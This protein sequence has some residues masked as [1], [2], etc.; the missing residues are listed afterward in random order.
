VATDLGI[1]AATSPPGVQVE[2]SDSHP[3]R[4]GGD[5]QNAL[6]EHYTFS[7]G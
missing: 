7:T 4:R 2:R 6:P 3:A 5:H 1:F